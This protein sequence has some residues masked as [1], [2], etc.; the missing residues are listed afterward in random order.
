M[1]A[2][3]SDLFGALYTD[4]DVTADLAAALLRRGYMAQSTAEAG[5]FG[6]TDEAQLIFEA[7]GG[8]PS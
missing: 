3:V 1:V 2:E 6:S 5:N 7:N 8:W 4:E